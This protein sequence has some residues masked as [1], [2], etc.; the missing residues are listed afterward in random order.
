[1]FN[2]HAYSPVLENIIEIYILSHQHNPN[3]GSLAWEKKET[4][5]RKVKWTLKLLLSWPRW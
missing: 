5:G 1:L 2:T 4:I 3:I